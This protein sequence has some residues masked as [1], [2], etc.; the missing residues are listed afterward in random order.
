MEELPDD[1]NETK[2]EIVEDPF[3]NIEHL[4]DENGVYRLKTRQIVSKN[5]EGTF[6]FFKDLFD[7]VLP[8]DQLDLFIQYYEN[9][10]ETHTNENIP[11]ID[12][13]KQLGFVE[14]S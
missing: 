12:K 4:K 10:P 5:K 7:R 13:L 6:E 1:N 8:N 2:N 3:K 14:R 9:H 11:Q